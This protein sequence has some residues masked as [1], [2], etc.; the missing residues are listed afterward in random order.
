MSIM[1]C[2]LVEVILAKGLE[3]TT[4][5]VIRF[6]RLNTINLD[7]LSSLSCFY[8]GSDTLLLSSLIRVIIW[9]CPNM[10]IFSQGVIDAKFFLGIQVSLDPNEDLFFYQDLNTTVKGMFQRQGFFKGLGKKCSFNCLKQHHGRVGQQNK[11]LCKLVTLK[12]DKCILPYAIPSAILPHLNNLEELQVRKSDKV[13][14]IFDM[15]DTE[16]IET[17]SRLKKLTLQGLSQLKRVWEKNSHG[18]LMFGNLQEI[19]VSECE[20]LQTL[21]P[22]LLAKNLEKLEKLEMKFC[23]KLQKI[24]EEEEG[25]AEKF[26]FPRLEKLDLC[27][28][29]QLTY[30]YPQTFTLECP[31]LNKLNVLFCDELELFQSASINRLPLVS[32]LKVVSNLKELKLD[33]KHISALSLRFK[34]E[35]F[36]EGLE[37]LN[38]ISLLFD[39]DENKKPVLPLQK[40]PDLTHLGLAYWKSP[41]IFL[42]EKPKIGVDGMRQLKILTLYHISELQSIESED[43]SWLNTIC[44]ELHVLN[45]VRC[46]HFTALVHSPST[47]SFYCLIKVSISNCPKLQ[48]LFTSSVGK[49]LMNLEEITI[50]EC[51]S[52][53]EIVSGESDEDKDEDEHKEGDDKFENEIIFEKLQILRLDSLPK[54]EGFYTGS[55]TLNLPSLKEVLFTECFN[56]KL[57][58]LGDKV[59]TKLNVTKDGVKWKSDP[60]KFCDHATVLGGNLK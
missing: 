46:I 12:L 20:N 10:K 14:V 51:E 34:S 18:V 11:W 55:S 52:V 56:T 33:W 49:K 41:G 19:F 9:E 27:D 13:R 24:V 6:E 25:T 31:T 17:P 22:S 40:A 43:S 29:P 58:R 5:E 7:S 1:Q 50:Q 57:F 45:V 59:P 42:A 26:V 21:F 36:G 28:L 3:E 8:S 15:N 44:E 23:F 48:Y 54:F 2:E 4:S 32:N 16:I 30:F 53:K 47:I 38:E 35:Q 60:Y 37:Y 39:A